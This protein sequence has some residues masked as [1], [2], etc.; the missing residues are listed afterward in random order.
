MRI[1]FS[2]TMCENDLN[3][4]VDVSMCAGAGACLSVDIVL[5]GFGSI[6]LARVPP[7]YTSSTKW[8]A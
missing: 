2:C 1:L 7:Q 5:L 6:R 4:H 8:I 3:V